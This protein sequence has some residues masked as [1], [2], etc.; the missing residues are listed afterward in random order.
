MDN[1][2]SSIFI[3]H[4]WA[5]HYLREVVNSWNLV[6]CIFSTKE[7]LKIGKGAYSGGGERSFPSEVLVKA[8]WRCGSQAGLLHRENT[9]RTG[10][11]V[12]KDRVGSN[13][14]WHGQCVGK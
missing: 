7:V 6:L 4:Y 11:E 13:A 14:S 2:R 1:P 3:V 5:F 10:T 12:G 9:L 8:S